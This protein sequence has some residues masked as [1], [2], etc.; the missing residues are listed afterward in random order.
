MATLVRHDFGVYVA[1]ATL[2]AQAAAGPAVPLTVTV[3]GQTSSPVTLA[4]AE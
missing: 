1:V 2:P 3:D 4:I